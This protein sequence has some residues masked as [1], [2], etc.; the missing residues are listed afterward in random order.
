[1]QR[2]LPWRIIE[3]LVIMEL[4]KGLAG[5]KGRSFFVSWIAVMYFLPLGAAAVAMENI[6]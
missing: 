2:Y 5:S 1:M 3:L 6:F 4:A